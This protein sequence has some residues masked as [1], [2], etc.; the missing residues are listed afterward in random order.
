M[1]GENDTLGNETFLEVQEEIEEEIVSEGWSQN[2]F[3]GLRASSTLHFF[4]ASKRRATCPH[5]PPS[6]VKP[7][8]C[9]ARPVLCPGNLR[10]PPLLG[11]A[12]WSYVCKGALEDA[13][14]TKSIISIML[15][16]LRSS[17]L[18]RIASL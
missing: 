4:F 12:R 14:V 11:T 1:D 3:V 10:R 8:T 13:Q 9:L 2:V 17:V 15:V 7:E 16:K 18:T 6:T 5:F